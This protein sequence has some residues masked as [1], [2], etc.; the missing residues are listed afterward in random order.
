LIAPKRFRSHGRV[1]AF[2]ALCALDATG[3][4][5]LNYLSAFLS[6]R[7]LHSDTEFPTRVKNVS[8]RFARQLAESV[9][10][11]RDDLDRRIRE[12]APRWA[13]VL[14]SPVDRNIL[15]LAVYE[16]LEGSK[17]AP[18]M[19]LSEALNLARTFGTNESPEL[20]R[21]TLNNIRHQLEMASAP[22][23]AP[24]P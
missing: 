11:N 23:P 6:D 9:W 14:L 21:D 15:R 7:E 4:K 18:E 22:P 19:I 24:A 16:L 13:G 3:D 8:L 10:Q 17:L 12:A 2:Q 1:L 5:F 20:V